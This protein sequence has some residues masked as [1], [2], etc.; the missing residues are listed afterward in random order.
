VTSPSA[1]AAASA[2]QAF[3]ESLGAPALLVIPGNH[4]IPLFNPTSR[5][6]K[7]YARFRAAFGTNLEPMFES[8]HLLAIAL[9]T[10]RRYRHTSGEVSETQI[11]R[12]A[13][14]LEQASAAQLCLIIMH[15]PVC[16]LRPE[17]KVDLLRGYTAA[18][19][20]WTAAGADLIMGGH[21]HFPFV[22][23][24]HEQRTDFTRQA[25]AV[26]A[27]TAVSGRVRHG[28]GNSVNLIRYGGQEPYRC[29]LIERWDFI[30]SKNEFD[31]VAVD[32]LRLE[33]SLT[34]NKDKTD[35]I[36]DK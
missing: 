7:P 26:Q 11:A 1:P 12:V 28:I 36:L 14:R 8:E 32:Q 17:N 35:V 24:L 23:A 6:F 13:K 2:A 9:N 3:I 10:T 21:S 18:V 27:G 22:C 25:W 4:D 29:C 34:L 33:A 5:L 30:S 19:Q 31:L 20:R 15:Q 16:V